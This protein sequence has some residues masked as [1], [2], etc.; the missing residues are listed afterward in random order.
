MTR[1]SLLAL[2]PLL[3]TACGDSGPASV[4]PP[5]PPPTAADVNIAPGAQ[6]KGSAAFSP[7]PKTVSL[8]GAATANVRWVNGDVSYDAYNGSTTVTHRIVSNDGTSFDTG[9]LGANDTS[10]KSLPAGTYAYHCMVH[11][12]MVGTVVVNP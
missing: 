6:T 2:L 7:N 1:L 8:A 11:P 10:L 4:N 12:A 9:S 3:A 5:A